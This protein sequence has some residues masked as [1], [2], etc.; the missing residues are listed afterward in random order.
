MA[1]DH[2]ALTRRSADEHAEAAIYG[3][4]ALYHGLDDDAED[5]QPKTGNQSSQMTLSMTCL[6]R[7]NRQRRDD[8]LHASNATGSLGS[9]PVL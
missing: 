6:R 3:L 8:Q 5:V 9:L 2:Q 1:A 7:L 4:V